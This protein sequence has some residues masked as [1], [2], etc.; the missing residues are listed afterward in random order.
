VEMNL[1]IRTSLITADQ[2]A[3]DTLDVLWRD[4]SFISY[5]PTVLS[6]NS[7]TEAVDVVFGFFTTNSCDQ[8]DALQMLMRARNVTSGEYYV[9]IQNGQ[10]RTP[11]PEHIPARFESI[12]QYLLDLS[13]AMGGKDPMEGWPVEFQLPI[14]IV[15]H[16]PGRDQIKENHPYFI[17]MV[18]HVTQ[19]VVAEREYLFRMLLYMRDCGFD[20]GGNVYVKTEDKDGIEE[21]KEEKKEYKKERSER[22]YMEKATCD[23]ISHEKYIEIN[24][25][26]IKT[27]EEKNQCYKYMVKRKYK[28]NN[29]PVWFLRAINGKNRQYTNITKYQ[30]L[31]GVV[32]QSRRFNM[33]KSIRDEEINKTRPVRD[34]ANELTRNLLT[35]EEVYD[36]VKDMD[37][38]WSNQEHMLCE[39]TIN[40]LKIIGAETFIRDVP[41]FDVEFREFTIAHLTEYVTKNAIYLRTLVNDFKTPMEKIINKVTSK[42]F[43][44][45]IRQTPTGYTVNNMWILNQHGLIWPYNKKNDGEELT[46]LAVTADAKTLRWV[47]NKVLQLRVMHAPQQ[48]ACVK[49][50]VNP[51]RY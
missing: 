5:S 12:K 10:R 8:A 13:K 50:Q 46:P 49:L 21:I 34:D 18:N 20:Y 6:G 44:I 43:G 1:N 24:K 15:P 27:N 22:K 45:K 2:R 17:S 7:Y 30:R 37:N 47:N 31:N 41:S 51:V 14:D 42:A 11:I 39:H 32:E 35:G 4:A 33:M 26:T 40:I 38:L 36:V 16:D 3:T 28:V 19:C 23:D 25:K 48:G 29:T 9:C